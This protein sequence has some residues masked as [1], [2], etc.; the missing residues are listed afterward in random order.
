MDVLTSR[1][2]DRSNLEIAG[3]GLVAISVFYA[4]NRALSGPR[5]KVVY[6]PGPPKDPF[7]G[8]LRQFPKDN[9]WSVFNKWQKEYGDIVFLDVPSLPFLLINSLDVAEELLSKRAS[10]TSGRKAG[11]MCKTLLGWDWK[12][13]FRQADETHQAIRKIF[14]LGIGPQR[15]SSFDHVIEQATDQWLLTAQDIKGDPVHPTF[16]K[17]GEVII[18]VAYG[19]GMWNNYG[20]ELVKLNNDSMVILASS[21]TQLWLV[22]IFNW[23][24]FIPSWMPGAEFRRRGIRSTKLTTRIREWPY[25]ESMKLFNSGNLGHSVLNDMLET[26]GPSD[27]LRD[28]VANLY[29]AGVDTTTCVV[30]LF[31]LSMLVFPDVAHKVQD[32][33]NS[34]IGSDR[35]PKVS[36]RA[37]LPYTEAVWKEA[38]R[39]NP[40]V[41]FGVP[42][43]NINEEYLKGYFIPK[44]SLINPNIGF[45]LNDPAI[46]GDPTV[47]RPERFLSSGASQLPNPLT[48]MFGFGLRVC[49]GMYLADRVGFH[50]VTKTLSVYNVVPLEGKEKPEPSSMKYSTG[51][52]RLPKNLEC[53]FVPRNEKA[54]ELLS[55][56]SFTI[57]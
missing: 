35:L 37:N 17:I 57:N 20:A 29:F 6:P 50:F 14:R 3:I 30:S 24:R 36:D 53:R 45:M 26:M 52:I 22:D 12:F 47:F 16:N 43:V 51:A 25:A 46:W 21:L 27:N 9:W 11:F 44:G 13:T 31:F 23:L 1:L 39:W 4:C 38:I 34:V 10:N 56:L 28:G 7:I 32:E 48:L 40:A 18:T 49:P 19:R 41:P 54:R 2:V 15:V 33:I 55:S 42:H 8:N 5:H